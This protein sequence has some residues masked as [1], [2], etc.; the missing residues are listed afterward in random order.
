MDAKIIRVALNGLENILKIGE[1]DAKE[2]GTPNH[3]ALV[4]EENYG[5][6][7]LYCLKLYFIIMI[8]QI[9]N[10]M[11]RL[12]ETQNKSLIKLASFSSFYIT[13]II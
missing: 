11:K 6:D 9:T 13:K 8:T 3:Y 10:I 4:I 7:F 5:N 2:K 1:M 12:H